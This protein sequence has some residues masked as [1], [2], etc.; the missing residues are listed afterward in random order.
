MANCHEIHIEARVPYN[1]TSHLTDEEAHCWCNFVLG[2]HGLDLDQIADGYID[3]N[4]HGGKT[5]M[6][7]VVLSGVEALRS[8]TMTML[9]HSL[10]KQGEIIEAIARDID[11]DDEFCEI[12]TPEEHEAMTERVHKQVEDMMKG[13]HWVTTDLGNGITQATLVDD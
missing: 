2:P 9:R 10:A 3:P 6:Y 13:K 5:A 1:W 12:L 8:G 7:R 4:E 11:N